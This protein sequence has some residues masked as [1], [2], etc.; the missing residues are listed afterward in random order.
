MDVCCSIGHF[1]QCRRY[2]LDVNRWKERHNERSMELRMMPSQV[3]EAIELENKQPD[4]VVQWDSPEKEHSPTKHTAS[5]S[6]YRSPLKPLQLGNSWTQG[7]WIA[8]Y[9][10]Y[11]V[12]LLYCP[13]YHISLRCGKESR[14]SPLQ[15]CCDF[16]A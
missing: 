8:S 12:A 16:Q 4:E 7:K 6:R 13:I 10:V 14:S 11:N 2:L 15:V 9:R 1:W 3:R 5:K